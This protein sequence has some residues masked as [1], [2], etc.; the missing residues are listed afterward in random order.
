LA[1]AT[2]VSLPW[3]T[4]ITS[5]C[6]VLWLIAIL[7]KLPSLPI[8][9]ILSTPAGALPVLIWGLAAL[10]VSWSSSSWAESLEAM[11]S[12]HK[13][14][15]IP[16]LMAWFHR[17]EHGMTALLGFLASCTLLLCY[18]TATLFWPSLMPRKSPVLGAPFK[19]YIQQSAAFITCA[20]SLLYFAIS[21]WQSHRRNLAAALFALGMLFIINITYMVTARATLLV[22]PVLLLLL[23][24]R[25]FGIKQAVV[26]CVAA[27]T[28]AG[29]VWA[30][31]P[32][33][34]T[35]VATVAAEIRDYR[36]M[37]ADTSAGLRLEFWRKSMEFVGS[38]PFAGHGTGSVK[39][40]FRETIA[41]RSGAAGTLADNPHNQILAIALQLGLL[42]TTLLYAMWT[43]HI[44][45]FRGSDLLLSV[46][47]M[48]VIQNIIYSLFNSHLFDF[49]PGW[50]YVFGVGILGA[51]AMKTAAQPA[52]GR[53]P[54][55]AASWRT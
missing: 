45:L 26:V 55:N 18:S 39:D 2:A 50:M 12:F 29:I 51:M 35:R 42:G 1:L 19:D 49:T 32:Y 33:L 16:L 40:L 4:S 41:G 24:L 30:T 15:V 25:H 37:N 53:P 54:S 52:S 48:V 31:S 27:F 14:L 34:R 6:V 13:L 20:F 21:S 22:L 46:G 11:R 47:L 7:P 38:A 5:V 10:G 17:S 43:A 9:R 23:V 28:T 3:S 36:S 44:L 8:V